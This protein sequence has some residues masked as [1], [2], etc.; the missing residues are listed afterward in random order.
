MKAFIV[1]IST[2]TILSA[3]CNNRTEPV[4][5]SDGGGLFELLPATQTGISFENT[6]TEGLNT[7]IL[8]YEY[9][10][11]GGG[12]ATGDFNNDG[13]SD[14]LFRNTSTGQ[15]DLWFMNADGTRLGD[16][17]T[18]YTSTSWTVAGTGKFN[19]DGI[20]DILWRNAVF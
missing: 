15:V 13:I 20:T 7:N 8:M 4:E 12:I 17:K 1:V 5:N 14:I 18:L 9:F 3:A 11:N 6:L 10:Y 2:L 16:V 19:A